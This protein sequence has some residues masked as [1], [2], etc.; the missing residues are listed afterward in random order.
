MA[1]KCGKKNLMFIPHFDVMCD[2]L[3]NIR[4]A[5]AISL[6]TGFLNYF[7]RQSRRLRASFAGERN[8]AEKSAPHSSRK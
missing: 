2:L 6:R 1:S 4:D 7:R 5:P 3:L 8:G